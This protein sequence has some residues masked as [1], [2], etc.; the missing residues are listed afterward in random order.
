MGY[1]R[2]CSAGLADEG[3]GGKKSPVNIRRE[4]NRRPRV[5]GTDA[6]TPLRIWRT[7]RMLGRSRGT[8]AAVAAEMQSVFRTTEAPGFHAAFHKGANLFLLLRR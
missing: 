5:C 6:T 4:K 8:S 3:I 1:I 7:V 2:F